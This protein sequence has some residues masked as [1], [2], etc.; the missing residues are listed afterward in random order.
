MA[1]YQSRQT[2]N[3]AENKQMFQGIALVFVLSFIAA[4]LII[5]DVLMN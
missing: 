1:S 3:K 4:L 2:R 5:Y